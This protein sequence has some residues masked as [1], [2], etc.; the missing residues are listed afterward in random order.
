[1]WVWSLGQEDL[2]R[3]WYRTPVFLPGESHGQ[4]S[5]VGYSPQGRKELDMTEWLHFTSGT[6][7]CTYSLSLE[8]WIAE[9]Q[10]A[11]KTVVL[12][13]L[14]SGTSEEE[15][16]VS[17]HDMS[18]WQSLPLPFPGHCAHPWFCTIHHSCPCNKCRWGCSAST[19]RTSVDTCSFCRFL[20]KRYAFCIFA[21]LRDS[22]YFTC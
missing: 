1:M 9:M 18:R 16:L 17:G 4:R 21:F 12:L 22:K 8:R 13:T 20:E 2:R 7:E 14:L 11:L 10:T 19:S 5:L 15:W 6:F 3:V